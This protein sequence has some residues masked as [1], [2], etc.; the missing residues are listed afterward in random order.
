MKLSVSKSLQSK[1]TAEKAGS[2]GRS[3]DAPAVQYKMQAAQMAFADQPTATQEG[4]RF[5]TVS[6][7]EF[8]LN[9]EINQLLET[10]QENPTPQKHQAMM[11]LIEQKR[12]AIKVKHV[13]LVG[14]VD[15]YEA[16]NQPEQT[17][18]F[19]S[20]L[21]D[22][23]QQFG[24]GAHANLGDGDLNHGQ[25]EALFNSLRGKTQSDP[26]LN[27]GQNDSVERSRFLVFMLQGM[28]DDIGVD[29]YRNLDRNIGQN[30]N[31]I[32]DRGP[33]DNLLGGVANN[34][35]VP[36]TR[37]TDD[38]GVGQDANLLQQGGSGLGYLNQK[39]ANGYNRTA[40]QNSANIGNVQVMM[41]EN[42]DVL[43]IF[44]GVD[45]QNNTKL[46]TAPKK[47]TVHHEVG[48]LNSMLEGKAGGGQG[49]KFA[50]DLRSLTDQ[51]EMYN[52]WGGPRS[53][54]AY[55]E[56]LGIPRRTDH[57]S[58]VP[59]RGDNQ[60]STHG[61]FIPVLESAYGFTNTIPQLQTLIITE[62]R[63]LANS[64]WGKITKGIWSAPDGVK[65]LRTLLEQNGVT[66]QQLQ[67]R[68]QQSGQNA[69]NDRHGF[70]QRFY[71]RVGGINV[72]SRDSLKTSLVALKQMVVPQVWGNGQ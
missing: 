64:T 58:L 16:S 32:I 57:R 14:I 7:E 25:I 37:K 56:E 27:N 51:E 36:H 13:T 24:G 26:G 20:Y 28:H 17:A 29:Q 30:R 11:L 45:Q 6:N 18:F 65:A 61:D 15:E 43:P 52:I 31:I 21:A 42:D 33:R 10:F 62:I 44:T 41:D 5:R 67:Q 60:G 53:D 69:D 22:K 12:Q 72:N 59:Y 50:G 1:A 70:T 39:F 2:S 19:T 68:A 48:H 3:F 49:K 66:L 63:R 4:V 71:N 23:P 47:M 8:Q 34:N 55:G 38:G 46:F 40:N 35:D 54:R 9:V